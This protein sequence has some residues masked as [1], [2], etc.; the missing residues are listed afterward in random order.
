MPV[1]PYVL[2]GSDVVAGVQRVLDGLV[3]AWCA[4]WGVPRDE[5]LLECMRAADGEAQLP[6][7]PAWRQAWRAG[8]GMLTLAWAA[9][10]PAQLQRLMFAPDRRHA[11][12]VGQAALAA[13][14]AAAAWLELVQQLAAGAMPD[15]TSD[16]QPQAPPRA[17]WGR[18]SG[19]LLLVLRLSRQVCHVL[20]NHEVVQALAQQARL[21]GHLR[22]EPAPALTAVDYM[23]LLAPVPV[24][25]PVEL[26]RAA[27]GLGSLMSLGIGDVIR[28]DVPADRALNV[29]G[30]AGQ[31]LFDGYLGLR[32]HTV[33]LEVVRH[34]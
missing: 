20:L 19:A 32:D 14:A 28:L 34:D 1:R 17:D 12:E 24:R 27:L 9:E 22:H 29:V 31:I 30:P 3:D 4:N 21:R 15:S 26:G 5:V 33:A 13:D 16:E 10:L 23:A 7:V 2:L 18:S 6:A 25:L 11:A 8:D